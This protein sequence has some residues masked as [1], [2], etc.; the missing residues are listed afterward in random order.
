MSI[1]YEAEAQRWRWQFKAVIDGERHRFSRRLPRG[2]SEAQARRYDEQETA[3]T[4]ARLSLGRRGNVP[5]VTTAVTVYLR[6]RVPLL[7]DGKHSAE[8]L[9]HMLNWLKGK[10]LDQLGDISRKYAKEARTLAGEPLGAATIRQRLA[11]L[12]SAAT[13]AL[14]H[15]GIGSRDW[16]EQITMPRVDNERQVFLRRAAVLRLARACRDPGTRALVLMAFA[17]GARPGELH[18]CVPV[19]D[20]LCSETKNGDRIAHPVLPRFA[21]LLRHWPMEYDYTYYSRHFRAARDAVGMPE[22]HLHDLRHSTA[23]ALLSGGHN[24]HAVA[25]VLGHKTVQS[26][27]RYAHLYPEAQQAALATIFRRK[28]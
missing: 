10:G 27:K 20:M 14:K 16:I 12:R 15:H 24:L 23:S 2:W 19:D 28:A 8:N 4:Y 11:T 17:T 22:V 21:Y 13:Y 18:R 3:R 5:L 7:K 26:T 25:Q 6:E 9:K 1:H